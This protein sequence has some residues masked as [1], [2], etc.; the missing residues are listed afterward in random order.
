L[1]FQPFQAP[2]W[3]DPKQSAPSSFRVAGVDLDDV[4]NVRS[5]PSPEHAVIG[6]ILPDADG[7]KIVGP[8]VSAWCPIQHRGLSGWVN[9]FYLKPSP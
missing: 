5:G 2:H 4:L 3:L 6:S 8:Y 1:C 9:S 7:I